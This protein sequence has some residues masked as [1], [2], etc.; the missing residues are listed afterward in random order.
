MVTPILRNRRDK[1]VLIVDIEWFQ[2]IR[3][4]GEKRSFYFQSYSHH[5]PI[6]VHHPLRS[7][8]HSYRSSG[9]AKVADAASGNSEWQSLWNCRCSVQFWIWR[10]EAFW[11]L[12]FQLL[13][14]NFS[15]MNFRYIVQPYYCG[16]IVLWDFWYLHIFSV[17]QWRGLQV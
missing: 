8:T 14:M 9:R 12:P 2:T 17:Q 10:V 5:P 15:T 1:S 11:F 6:R 13:Q 16:V 4:L 3:I 7:R